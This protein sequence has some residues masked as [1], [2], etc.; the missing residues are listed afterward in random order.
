MARI[1]I[2]FPIFVVFFPS[3]FIINNQFHISGTLN[4]H[5][6]HLLKVLLVASGWFTKTEK[7]IMMISPQGMEL[8]K[9]SNVSFLEAI[10]VSFMEL[11]LYVIAVDEFPDQP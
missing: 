5:A 3:F 4:I 7:E 9:M 11:F 2:L 6:F 10:S 8:H 1:N